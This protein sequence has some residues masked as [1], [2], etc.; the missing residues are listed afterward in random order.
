MTRTVA[1]VS[2]VLVGAAIACAPPPPSSVRYDWI[3]PEN[4]R[5]DAMAE[6]ALILGAIDAR[7]GETVADIGAGGGYFSFKLAALVG[8]EGKVVATDSSRDCVR[9]IRKHSRAGGFDNVVSL[10]V[11][12]D[13]VGTDE[14]FDKVLMADLFYF[15]DPGETRDYFWKLSGQMAPESRLVIHQSE[16]GCPPAGPD[17]GWSG[18][19]LSGEEMAAALE[20][21]FEVERR[22]DLGEENRARGSYLLVFRRKEPREA[23]SPIP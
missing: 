3:K 22:V 16:S 14:V 15:T 20:G 1:V 7:P 10:H 11:D 2:A 17:A 12:P 8:P 5:R 21:S 6:T 9:R 18:C 23:I 19:V 13:E 4:P